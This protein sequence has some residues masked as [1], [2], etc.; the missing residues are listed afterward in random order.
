VAEDPR[1]NTL[2]R[3]SEITLFL[4]DDATEYAEPETLRRLIKRYSE[5]I[6]FPIYLKS[7]KTETVEVPVEEAA[8]EA[9]SATPKP[10]PADD[11]DEEA[12][13]AEEDSKD[14]AADKKKTKT[15]TREVT[16]W[17]LVNDQ[18]AIWQRKPRD[19]SDAEYTS[20]YTSITK[21]TDEPITWTHFTA[22]GEVEFRAI[23]YVPG[24]AP[25]DLY[26]NYYAKHS[27]LRLYVR[28]VLISDE[29]EELLPRYLNFVR[30]V[31]DSDDLP[32]NVSRETLQQHKILKV[33]GKKL[34]RKVLEML[35]KLA[36]DQKRAR[37]EAEEKKAASDKEEEGEGGKKA[38]KKEPLREGAD[39]AFDKFWEVF[40][41]N[42]KLGI[43]EDSS[44]R[45]V[46][47]D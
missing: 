45:C 31:V 37:E 3:G 1:G 19:I 44:N 10:T 36:D 2:G 5:F 28:K 23:L 38:S 17:E 15:E 6:T 21:A 13:E 47:L 46:A 18:K 39:K 29:F 14:A 33:M 32:L 42:V 24:T 35:K 41:K 22:E 16:S 26:D 12:V 43:I 20:F 8:D 30:G 4:K 9:A 34:V 11:E 27:S 40:G 7:T 25:P